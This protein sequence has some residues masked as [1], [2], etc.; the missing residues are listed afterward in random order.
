MMVADRE[1]EPGSPS[2]QRPRGVAVSGASGLVGRALERSLAADGYTVFRLVRR[3]A[4]SESEIGYDP[5]AGRV[6]E[7]RLEGLHAVVHLAG[8]NIAGGRWNRERKHR[9]RASRVDG[10]STVARAIAGLAR[11]PRVLISASAIGFYGDRGDET[12]DETSSAGSGFLPEVCQA[13]EAATEPAERAGVRVVRLR[14]GVVLSRNGGALARMLLPFRLGLGGRLGDGRQTMSWLSRTDLV[15]IIHH[16][17]E[18][19]GI[20]GAV[21]AVA[22]FPVTNAEYTRTLARILRRPAF[23]T[24]PAI[25]LRLL[26]GEMGRDLLLASARVV[27]RAL[28]ASGFVFRH[29]QLEQALR[30]ELLSEP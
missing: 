4:A 6:D 18:Q 16:C 14:V 25:C 10:T 9:I 3:G 19:D 21:N 29:P 27:P 15:A 23:A 13:W 28:E 8:E 17:L 5:F 24:V 20:A 7:S 11:P 1:N 22:P 30:F 2:V 26:L 12:L